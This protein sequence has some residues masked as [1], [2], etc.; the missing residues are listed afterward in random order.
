MS[1]YSRSYGFAWSPVALDYRRSGGSEL[2]AEK[3]N[4]EIMAN[5]VATVI[6]LE[7]VAFLRGCRRGRAEVDHWWALA[8]GLLAPAAKAVHSVIVNRRIDILAQDGPAG[9]ASIDHQVS[10]VGVRSAGSV[11][12]EH[13]GS[14]E[15]VHG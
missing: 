8:L 12:D 3:P 13:A 6:G 10:S 7:S 2:V 9:Q 4:L 14:G 1:S 5:W 11:D 15:E